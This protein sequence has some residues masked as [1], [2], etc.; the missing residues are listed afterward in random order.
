MRDRI[1]RDFVKNS[2]ALLDTEHS[3][4]NSSREEEL[5]S[6][7]D[8]GGK[9]QHISYPPLLELKIIYFTHFTTKCKVKISLFTS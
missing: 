2:T 4:Q 8:C 1:N 6:G 9:T 5:Q 3:K 7:S